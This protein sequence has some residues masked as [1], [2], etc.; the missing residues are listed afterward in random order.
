LY[1]TLSSANW[2]EPLRR[3][4]NSSCA[5]SASIEGGE[6]G[7]GSGVIAEG[8]AEVGETID[9]SRG[10]DE[11]AAELK[12][13]LAKFVLLVAGGAGALAAF[14]IVAAKQVKEI[15]GTQIS[16]GIRL[17]F[18]IHEQG[19]RDAGFFEEKACIVAVTKTD[20]GERSAFVQEGLL[21]FAQL[22]DVLAAKDSAVVAEKNDDGRAALP[23]RTQTDFAA[24]GVRENDFCELL[25]KSLLH[26]EHD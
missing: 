12:G 20:G 11:A 25:A 2:N 21:V 15:G 16:D 13:I 9:I 22:R 18:F 6:E 17:T 8:F 14:E 4:E 26:G 5:W 7:G 10:E 19:K 24:V 1:S 23:Q 3:V